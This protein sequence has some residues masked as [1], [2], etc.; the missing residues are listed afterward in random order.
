MAS[1][2]A[3]SQAEAAETLGELGR[4]LS[5]SLDPAVVA[6]QI[7]A[8]VRSL[9]GTQL[10]VVYR[11]DPRSGDLIVL[12]RSG[13]L[14]PLDVLRQGRGLASLVVREGRAVVTSDVTTDP[15][16]EFTPE[17]RAAVAQ[18]A[19][20]VLACVP[21]T[22]GGV[23]IGVLAAGDLPGRVF[24]SE[25]I[26]LLQSLAD[27]AAV[28]LEN[29]RVYRESETR[30]QEAEALAAVSRLLLETLDRGA[31][32]RRIAESVQALLGARGAILREL[33]S[34]GTLI[35]IGAS[36][37]APLDPSIRLGPGMG[38]AGV[39]VQEGRPLAT[40]DFR[41][42]PR[43]ALPPNINAQLGQEDRALLGVP[44][45][46]LSGI[47]GTLVV[48][49]RK[50]RVF[51]D[52]EIRLALAFADA[53]A[54]ALQNT[55]LYAEADRRRRE[56]EVLAEVERSISESMDPELV[57]ARVTEGARELCGADAARIALRVP[58]ESVMAFQHGVG[59]QPD[60]WR[61]VRIGPGMGAG[62]YV[63]QTGRSFRTDNYPED[64]RISP[65]FREDGRLT[66]TV[67][68][69]V[70]PIPGEE[71]VEGLLYVI[72]RSPRLFTDQDEAVLNRLADHAA[73]ALR[74]SHL[75]AREQEARAAAEMS[76]GTL[77]LLFESS[78][79]PMLV[80][81]RVTFEILEVNET[82]IIHLGCTREDLLGHRTTELLVPEDHDRLRALQREVLQAPPLGT[83]RTGPWRYRRKDGTVIDLEA[84]SH[85]LDYHGRAARLAVL[86]DVTE[87]LR[88]EAEAH[89]LAAIV[90]S[91]DD[92][93]LS[94]DLDGLVR[95]WNPGAERMLGYSSAEATGQPAIRL[96]PADREGELREI[97]ARV[98]RGEAVER[99]ETVGLT[100]AGKLIDVALTISPIRD[101]AGRLIAVSVI[102]R[103]ITEQR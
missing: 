25:E 51:T 71:R 78:P 56:A 76:A 85:A 4:L 81:D 37:A 27:T 30:R 58:G 65:E 103:D 82:A 59:P 52:D 96:A 63:L 13:E 60:D 32:A 11:L 100:K 41:S 5:Q 83:L 38:I 36:G 17:E 18:R 84:A 54:L 93:I 22:A 19:I 80:F 95:S 79:L 33:D 49:D 7:V 14:G 34:T 101:A 28:A 10:A 16:I 45:R 62:G 74:N 89:R 69:I 102:A 29:A 90:Q 44:L 23:V 97:L 57:L 8:S 6:E 2:R 87:R 12:A 20:R 99:F 35:T 46:T 9:V 48:S 88:A 24:S 1:P 86:I 61:Q 72:N 43:L 98:I 73:V 66:S 91:A 92:A 39:V 42:D 70:V 53:G 3:R 21:L 15:R 55:R 77:R 64:P 40:P 75:F 67:A 31:I 68:E 50:G 94:T 26:R 47:I